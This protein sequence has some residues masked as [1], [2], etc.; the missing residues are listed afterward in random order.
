MA[1]V[2]GLICATTTC[3]SG[4]LLSVSRIGTQS[5]KSAK[6]KSANSCHSAIKDCNRFKSDSL[7][8]LV[9]VSS[10]NP[11]MTNLLVLANT[12]QF[13]EWQT[14]AVRHLQAPIAKVNQLLQLILPDLK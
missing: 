7:S 11:G 13:L 3:P 5:N 6:D 14:I 1:A 9:L 10:S 8:E 12:N 4:Q 2:V